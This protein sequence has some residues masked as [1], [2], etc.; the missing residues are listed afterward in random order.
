MLRCGANNARLQQKSG[1][2]SLTEETHR[3]G[4]RHLVR[5]QKDLQRLSVG[6]TRRRSLARG[7]PA[8]LR[9][10]FPDTISQS[11]QNLSDDAR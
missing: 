2:V 6:L 8:G 5:G 9:H 1:S 10:A 4:R 11:T 7:Q 3:I